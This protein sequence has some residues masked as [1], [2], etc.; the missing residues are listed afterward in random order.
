LNI[1]CIAIV[2]AG[3]CWKAGTINPYTYEGEHRKYFVSTGDFING[4]SFDGSVTA[5]LISAFG[6]LYFLY[7]DQKVYSLLSLITVL[8][9]GSNFIDIVLMAVLLF[10]AFFYSNRVQ[11]SMVLVYL[12]MITVFWAKVSPQNKDYTAQLLGQADGKTR[13]D[14][15]LPLPHPTMNEF[16]EKK[17]VVERKAQLASFMDTLYPVAKKDSLTAG[18]KGW[19]RSGRWIAWQ[20]LANFYRDHPS[21]LLLGAGM[22]NFSSRLAFKTAAVNI[23]GSYPGRERYIHPLFRDNYLYLYLYYHTRDEGQHSVIN[24]PDG[25][26]GQLLGEYG[27]IGIGCFFLLYAGFFLQRVRLLSY[28]LPLLLLLGASF[29]TEYWFEQLSVVVLFEFLMLL[30]LSGA[31]RPEIPKP[32]INYVIEP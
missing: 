20:E 31:S 8:L 7:R 19:D 10:A 1:A 22:G 21:Q 15:P 25:V 3:I 29:F 24:K 9:A 4:I 23:E 32:V 12:L 18:Y 26:Y 17:V 13:Y 11:K 30:D 28:G 16:V 2:F 27:L 5:A 14:P 6:V